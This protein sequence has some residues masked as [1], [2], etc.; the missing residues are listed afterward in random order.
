MVT[1]VQSTTPRAPS[2]QQRYLTLET[3]WRAP[4]PS[5][6]SRIPSRR[7]RGSG[8]AVVIGGANPS[9]IL[10][11]SILEK[12]I[13]LLLLACPDIV[14]I[15]EQPPAVTFLDE[16]GRER[17]HVFDFLVKKRDGSTIAVDVKPST[18]V[19]R[20]KPTF[21]KIIEKIGSYADAYV[22]LS[23]ENFTRD[24]LHNAELIQAVRR[25]PNPS[26]DDNIRAL[27][28]DMHGCVRIRDLVEESG[29]D[30]G[31]FRAIVRL[32]A[33]KELQLVEGGRINHAAFVAKPDGVLLGGAS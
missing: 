23:E 33:A 27:I 3:V 5:R 26:Y 11:E 4:A 15:V 9:A 29:L 32:I 7:S 13:L 2:Y 18:R 21:L 19:A 10:C 31:G 12:K 25:D 1:I 28:A 20:F 6:A 24:E 30:G 16:K 8:R 22:L 14:D 17:R